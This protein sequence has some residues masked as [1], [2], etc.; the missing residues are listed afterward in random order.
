MGARHSV[1]R[2]GGIQDD[3]EQESG[4]PASPASYTIEPVPQGLE[5]VVYPKYE[6]AFRLGLAAFNNPMRTNK[7]KR[8]LPPIFG[9]PE[10]LKHPNCGITPLQAPEP[11]AQD[12]QKEM[13][14]DKE[15][16]NANLRIGAYGSNGELPEDDSDCGAKVRFSIA[17]SDNGNIT[18]ECAQSAEGMRL[19][20]SAVSGAEDGLLSGANNRSMSQKSKS[21]GSTIVLHSTSSAG[22]MDSPTPSSDNIRISNLTTPIEEQLEEARIRNANAKRS[23]RV[24]SSSLD[25]FS[26][27]ATKSQGSQN[28]EKLLGELDGGL[29]DADEDLSSEILKLSLFSPSEEA[30]PQF[31][32][33]ASASRPNE[34]IPATKVEHDAY[35]DLSHLIEKPT[36]D[37]EDDLRL[38]EKVYDCIHQWQYCVSSHKS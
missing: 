25:P 32:P 12:V 28:L 31:D 2:S 29:F 17:K 23:N 5:H 35:E 18:P 33:V 16:L 13:P 38:L 8:D 6:E 11:V 21:H 36:M 34:V 14:S 20:V 1:A 24:E 26:K 15:L 30:T 3:G 7:F 4:G 9:T 37:V 27:Y 19:V 10:F 22:S